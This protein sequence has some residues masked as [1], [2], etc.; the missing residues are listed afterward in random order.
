[1]GLQ[2]PSVPRPA[3]PRSL[4]W[5]LWG[6]AWASLEAPQRAL[7]CSR[8][9]ETEPGPVP[10]PRPVSRS[11]PAPAASWWP[12]F[13]PAASGGFLPWPRAW[14]PVVWRLLWL[15]LP[16]QSP[17]LGLLRA[18]GRS[19]GLAA[20]VPASPPQRQPPRGQRPCLA[21]S[22]KHPRHQEDCCYYSHF[23]GEETEAKR[24]LNLR[25]VK[26]LGSG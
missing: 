21:C 6:V 12:P 14:L 2:N 3:P 4:M 9:R 23:T 17:G 20:T 10:T 25:R 11:G 7:S 16:C 8:S 22:P 26:K 15:L 19:R 13:P 5:S 24:S 1:M 18:C